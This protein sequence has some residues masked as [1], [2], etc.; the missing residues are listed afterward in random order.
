MIKFLNRTDIRLKL[1]VGLLSIVL[2]TGAL[3]IL[4]GVRIIDRNVI[5][6]AQDSVESSLAATEFLYRE[7]IAKRS[8][9]VNY[10][11]KTSEIVQAVARG[12]RE[13]LFTK[14][15]Q[16]KKEFEFDIVNLVDA[17][18][19][20]LVRANNFEEYGDSIAHYSYI[21]W[22]LEN[23]EP[24]FG[25][26]ILENEDIRREGPMLA[27]R[28]LIPVIPTPHAQP[29]DVLVEDRALVIKLVA[30]VMSGRRMI[31]ILYA[32]IVLNNNETFIDRFKNLVFRD[33]E[34]NGKEVGTT[35]IFLGDVRV[36]TNVKDRDGR[37]AIGTQVS[38]E[39][40][41]EVFEEGRTFVG[42]AFVVDA[43]YLSGYTPIYDIHDRRI[44]ILYAGILEDKFNAILRET[45]VSFLQVIALTT[46]LALAVA[47]YL[48]GAATR[49]VK[50]IIT[51]S[52]EIARG[53]YAKIEIRHGDDQDIRNIGTA[54]NKMTE[55]IEERDRWLKNLAETSILKSEK[56]ASIGRL[57]SGIAHEINNPLTGVLTYSC[58]LLEELK[59]TP[60]EDD[61]KVIQ[62]ETLRCR[63]I[64]RGLLDFARDSRPEKIDVDINA[65]IDASL[66]ILEKNVSF[67]NITIVRDY[68]RSLPLISVD[69]GQIRS[70]I[71][72]LAVNAADAMP[73]GGRLTIT[74]RRDPSGDEIVIQF[75]DTGVGIS[76]E[77]MKKLFE[78]FFT[79][80]DK[81][82]GTGLGLAV[83]YGVI[84][85]HN[86]SISVRSKVGEG[87]EFTIRLPRR[88]AGPDPNPW[89]SAKEES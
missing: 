56:L 44:G 87:T 73:E 19:R 68:D 37:R 15:E 43:W 83:T 13:F 24:V 14:L 88:E 80:K 89:E 12:D 31:G 63:T 36:A 34:F 77:N 55:A 79:T 50:R 26:G 86:G 70:V 47:V 60:H 62:D 27:T 67:Q 76:G 3:S 46:I 25:T 66:R 53:N 48:I 61:L 10:L 9:I 84:Q 1:I 28:T 18:G 75:A 30:P 22:V 21:K 32:A 11:S 41:R 54:F 39:V 38:E 58:L 78:P 59:G 16:I 49:P 72:N 45:T 35:T 64:V 40:F 23:R 20:V 7:E 2:L 81:G 82:K 33:E 5:R 57:A 74:T 69:T 6:E 52:A 71:N 4:V 29:R 17:N 42:K 51:A 85:R 8:R 65:L